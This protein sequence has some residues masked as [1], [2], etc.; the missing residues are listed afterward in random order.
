MQKVTSPNHRLSDRER[1]ILQWVAEGKSNWDVSAILNISER[2]VK[3]HVG[4][5]MKKLNAVNRTHA[6]AIA[7]HD[8]IIE[9]K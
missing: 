7:M 1:E 2:T 3:F 8:E 9:I 5:I 4:S 6:V